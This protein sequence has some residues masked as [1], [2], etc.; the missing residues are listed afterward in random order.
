[1][2]DSIYAVWERP[3]ARGSLL[4]ALAYK[5]KRV[6][7]GTGTFHFCTRRF[8]GGL[9]HVWFKPDLPD[10]PWHYV[11]V[12]YDPG[13]KLCFARMLRAATPYEALAVLHAAY[14]GDG[15]SDTRNDVRPAADA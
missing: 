1:M 15:F 4:H 13:G 8:S 10:S 2:P 11:P 5:H 6:H 14:E 12:A 3:G 9:T 7:L